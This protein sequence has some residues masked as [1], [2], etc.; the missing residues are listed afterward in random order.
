MQG[1]LCVRS[2]PGARGLP[3]PTA[4]HVS[5]RLQPFWHCHNVACPGRT[6][7]GSLTA[8]GW[9]GAEM[10]RGGCCTLGQC[11]ELRLVQGCRWVEKRCSRLYAVSEVRRVAHLNALPTTTGGDNGP[12]GSLSLYHMPTPLAVAL[13]LPTPSTTCVHARSSEIHMPW[14]RWQQPSHV[15]LCVMYR[16]AGL[17][18]TSAHV[19]EHNRTQ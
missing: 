18:P 8:A 10:S 17:R 9:G 14:R 2:G 12:L 4:T 11:V 13:E 15:L 7:A 1:H 5:L 6:Y 3:A 16:P 19:D